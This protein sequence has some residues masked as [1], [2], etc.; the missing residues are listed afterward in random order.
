[1]KSELF[2]KAAIDAKSRRLH[3]E[4]ILQQTF[5]TR[6][7][8]GVI[9]IIVALSGVWLATGKFARTEPAKGILVP[10]DGASKVYA[11]RPG[12]VS[13]LM[14]KDGDVV[15][16]GQKLAVITIE[17][18]NASGSYSAAE[19]LSSISL[20]ETMANEQIELTSRRSRGETAKIGR[21]IEG[22]KAQKSDIFEQIALQK[23]MVASSSAT[24]DQLK[25]VVEKGFVSKLE[26]ERRRQGFISAKQ[27]LSRLKQQLT[28]IESDIIRST[29][30]LERLSL[31]GKT[32]QVSTRSAIE[33][34]KQQRTKVQE[35]VSYLIKSP[36]SG[37][38]TAIQTRPGRATSSTV[39]LL[40]IVPNTSRLK[41]DIYVPSRAI[42][43][44]RSNQ[45]VRLLYD[46]FPYQRFGSFTARIDTISRV[47]VAG[48]ETDAPFKI[49]EPVYR[50]T[51]I[52]NRQHVNAYGKTI[53]LQPGMTLVA[54]IILER[55]SFLE[56]L[57]SPL[58]AVANRN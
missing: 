27:E 40:V 51:A 7:L 35:G 33:T 24:F 22:L 58:R 44:I 30:E 16:A 41:A 23:E 3:G 54:N 19:T 38:V 34:L 4:V 13:G 12:I 17:T 37:V 56:W 5:S 26:Y 28:S 52:P 1:M 39:P 25:A 53:S 9:M 55:Q 6:A 11:M 47:A 49:E 43:F 36:V 18:P 48:E 20:Q 57:L 31:D 14:V 15:K 8:T 2:R 32:D 42:G 21:A 50:I 46:A 29:D 45:E 10:I